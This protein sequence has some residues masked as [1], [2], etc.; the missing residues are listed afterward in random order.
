MALDVITCPVCKQ[1]LGLYKYWTLG[2]IVVCANP[3]CGTSLRIVKRKPILVEI[4]P[5]EQTYHPD[6]RPESYG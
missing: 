5:E 6:Y 3:Q 4:V 2:S 1:K